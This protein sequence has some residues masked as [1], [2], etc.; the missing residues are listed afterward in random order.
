MMTEKTI[1]ANKKKNNTKPSTK[2]KQIRNQ[3][4]S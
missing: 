3:F 2:T 4:Q 1:A